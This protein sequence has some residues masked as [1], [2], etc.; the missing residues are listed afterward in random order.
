MK[1]TNTFE[2]VPLTESARE[3][4]LRFLDASAACW[5]EVNYTR[6]QRFFDGDDVWAVDCI[7]DYVDVL[8]GATAQSMI[9]RNESA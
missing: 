2:A 1:R 7:Y 4:L 5:S 3:L 6:R 9:K 8:G